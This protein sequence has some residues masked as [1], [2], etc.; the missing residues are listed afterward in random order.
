MKK[1]YQLVCVKWYDAF[2]EDTWDGHETTIDLKDAACVTVGFIVRESKEFISIASTLAES[3]EKTCI[4]NIP[5]GMIQK[6]NKLKLPKQ[7][8]LQT[9]MSCV[10]Y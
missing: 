7:I 5:R 8:G 6:L 9:S 4:F 10:K 2:T 3:G 1:P